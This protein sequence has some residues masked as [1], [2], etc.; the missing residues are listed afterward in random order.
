MTEIRRFKKHNAINMPTRT[1]F[2]DSP[3]NR[4]ESITLA[5]EYHRYSRVPGYQPAVYTAKLKST[6]WD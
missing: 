4:C 1:A 2:R 6:G 5:A 3:N